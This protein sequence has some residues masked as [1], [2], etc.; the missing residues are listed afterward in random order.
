M[1]L[2]KPL[3]SG[4]R[5]HRTIL[6]EE[7]ETLLKTS[8]GT[9]EEDNK[10]LFLTET[11]ITLRKNTSYCLNPNSHITL[12]ISAPLRKRKFLPFTL[13]LDFAP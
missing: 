5:L 1:K 10:D 13:F 4:V 7:I 12:V 8:T 3:S 11:L 6:E 2:F 9:G